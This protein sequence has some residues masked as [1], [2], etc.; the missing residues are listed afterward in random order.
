MG[1]LPSR[2]GIIQGTQLG[3]HIGF[4]RLGS[5]SLPVFFL[6]VC[7]PPLAPVPCPQTPCLAFSISGLATYP[8]PRVLFSAGEGKR[9]WLLSRDAYV[10]VRDPRYCLLTPASSGGEKGL[11]SK[12]G[13]AGPREWTLGDSHPLFPLTKCPGDPWLRP[14]QGLAQWQGKGAPHSTSKSFDCPPP[15]HP[16]HPPP[17]QLPLP[18]VT[19]SKAGQLSYAIFYTVLHK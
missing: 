14:A 17:L 13:P 6:S 8:I 1:D 11:G 18:S 7:T 2:E 10:D 4:V 5:P 15:Y 12:G 9:C 19:G 3:P 16:D